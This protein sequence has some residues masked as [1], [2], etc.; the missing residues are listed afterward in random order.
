MSKVL[1]ERPS[2]DD[3]L[4]VEQRLAAVGWTLI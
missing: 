3:I 1:G 2:D 4:R